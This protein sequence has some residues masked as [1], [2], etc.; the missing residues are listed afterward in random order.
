MAVYKRSYHGYAGPLMPE[1]SRFLILSRQA[2]RSIFSERWMT[3]FFIVCCFPFLI[4]AAMIYVAHSASVMS[5]FK[6][7]SGSLIDINATFFYRVLSSQSGL[8]FVMAA[9]VGPGL[10]SPDLTNNGLVLYLCRPFSRTEYVLGK[11]VVIAVLLSAI[12][13]IPGLL[14]FTMQAA[15]A[16][17]SWTWSNLYL[18]GSILIAS[19]ILIIA[20]S[21][22]ALAMSAWVKWRPV[23]G[24]LVL[25]VLFLGSSF[26]WAINAVMR[27]QHG[28]LI[29]IPIQISRIWQALFSQ[30]TD[31]GSTGEAWFAITATSAL[32]LY[33]LSRKL[34]AYEVVR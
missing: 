30:P 11:F 32:C 18:I 29:G 16:G 7:P 4:S 13:W 10:V 34:R 6:L 26:G 21:L 25:G 15:L 31:P 14:L 1:W 28:L 23:A 5:I 22:L 33:L 2:W 12:T 27:T 3:G 9:F 17:W 19:W 8:A 24:A 20:L